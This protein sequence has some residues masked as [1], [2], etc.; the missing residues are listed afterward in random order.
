M[1]PLWG[2]P[3]PVASLAKIM[4]GADCNPEQWSPEIRAEDMKLMV[5][6]GC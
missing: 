4:F 5:D 1:R 3:Q 2:D 6:A